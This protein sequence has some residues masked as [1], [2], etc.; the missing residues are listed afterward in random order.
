MGR[1]RSLDYIS[2]IYIAKKKMYTNRRGKNLQ[3]ATRRNP[4]NE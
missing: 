4:T 1:E 2:R 3:I